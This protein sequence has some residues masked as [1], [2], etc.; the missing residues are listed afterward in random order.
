MDSFYFRTNEIKQSNLVKGFYKNIDKNILIKMKDIKFMAIDD[1]NFNI[2]FHLKNNDKYNFTFI[3]EHCFNNFCASRKYLI[4]KTI[5]ELED[6]KY[7]I[8]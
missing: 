2:E 6:N 1:I 3:N 5:K 8:P 4:I 7:I